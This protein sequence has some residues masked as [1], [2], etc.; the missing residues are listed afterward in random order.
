[1]VLALLV[2]T[3]KPGCWLIEANAAPAD[4]PSDARRCRAEGRRCA[5]GGRCGGHLVRRHLCHLCCP[6]SLAHVSKALACESCPT[7]EQLLSASQKHRAMSL[8]QSCASLV[9]QVGR[10]T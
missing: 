10:E 1:M 2:R 4:V 6:S 3:S 8:V 5:E 7:H 9:T